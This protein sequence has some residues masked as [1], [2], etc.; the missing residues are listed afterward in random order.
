[1]SFSGPWTVSFDP[2][3]GGPKQVVFDRLQ[4]W[5]LR[6][7]EGIKYYSG[8]A[9]YEKEFQIPEE[10]NRESSK[11][12]FINLGEVYDMARV[13]ING[14]DM[15]VVWTD[16]FQLKITKA[17]KPGINQI[18]IEVA[19]RWPNRLIG[20]ERLPDD[21][22]KDGKWPDWFLKK[23][24]RTSGRFTFTTAN[25]YTRDSPLLLSGLLGPVRILV[26]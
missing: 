11:E 22:I 15:G 17:L 12:Y 23:Q 5:T 8:I 6:G 7:E 13:W 24:A 18:V 1:L 25:F 10:F 26:Q 21:G 9:K 3:W 19:N 20:D 4:D 16:P 2:K 14:K